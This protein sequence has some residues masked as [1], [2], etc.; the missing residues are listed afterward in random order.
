MSEQLT[1][2]ERNCPSG[3]T[4]RR[5]AAIQTT[6]RVGLQ[7][8][9]WEIDRDACGCQ[10]VLGMRLDDSERTFVIRPCTKHPDLAEETLMKLR[11][12]VGQDRPIHTLAGEIFEAK[13]AKAG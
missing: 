13:L 11:M 7:L 12:M 10:M 2:V 6:E 3:W 8:V 1:P 9:G 5:V 4:A